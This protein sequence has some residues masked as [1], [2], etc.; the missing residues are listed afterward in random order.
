MIKKAALAIASYLLIVL[1]VVG[2][3]FVVDYSERLEIGNT[4]NLWAFG[5]FILL[6]GHIAIGVYGIIKAVAPADKES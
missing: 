6:T 1:G 3:W 4:K 5:V 2:S